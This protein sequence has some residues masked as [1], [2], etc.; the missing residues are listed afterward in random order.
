MN[1]SAI[2][3]RENVSDFRERPPEYGSP[4]NGDASYRQCDGISQITFMIIHLPLFRD[5]WM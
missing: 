5:R 3:K 1:F 2:T 4:S